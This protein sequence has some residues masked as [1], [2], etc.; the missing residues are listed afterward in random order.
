M[1][2][3]E[4]NVTAY[5]FDISE[6]LSLFS[7]TGEMLLS[8]EYMTLVEPAIRHTIRRLGFPTAES[9]YDREE[10]IEVFRALTPDL[11]DYLEQFLYQRITS[12]PVGTD[13]ELHFVVSGNGLWF[14]QL[15]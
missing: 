2:Y 4:R 8:P 5:R 6:L 15:Q 11:K 9:Y 10:M 13:F 3:V 7:Q 12:L 1:S 14:F